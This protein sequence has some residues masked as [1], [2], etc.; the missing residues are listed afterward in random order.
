M[1]D[2][3]LSETANRFSFAVYGAVTSVENEAFMARNAAAILTTTGAAGICLAGMLG[4]NQHYGSYLR[5]T[6]SDRLYKIAL[7]EASTIA[8]NDKDRRIIPVDI[9][10]DFKP[11]RL[12]PL[13]L[14]AAFCKM[15]GCDEM[16]NIP[17]ENIA[18]YSH[19]KKFPKHLRAARQ[20]FCRDAQESLSGFLD[21][22]VSQISRHMGYRFNVKQ[23][24]LPDLINAAM[25]R[26]VD[27]KM[28]PLSTWFNIC[29]HDTLGYLN[30]QPLETLAIETPSRVEHA[31][32]L[33]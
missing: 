12:W 1:G 15:H 6:I 18:I 9:L 13:A 7:E 3:S 26:N 2:L 19:S 27:F 28:N 16:G 23:E 8:Q 14:Q 17:G 10:E 32:L 5:E 30:Q 4:K 33:N 25:D 31:L 21:E 20:N 22:S 24:W 11:E 29:L